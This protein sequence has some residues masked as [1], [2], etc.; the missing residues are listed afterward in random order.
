MTQYSAN[1]TPGVFWL[2]FS[3]IGRVAR[4][5][6]WLGFLIIWLVIGIA[7]NMWL[8]T[9]DPGMEFEA[10]PLGE[11]MSSNPLFPLLFFVLQWVQLALVIKR[12]QDRGITGF[13]A[14]LVF[15]PFLSM[16]V[17]IVLGIVPGTPG[18]NRYGPQSNSYYRRK[19]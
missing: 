8:K 18:P 14:L 4:E 17:V 10:L 9:L 13:L 19:A 12:C 1:T 15:L 6:Y 7:A 5:A 11:F 3:P 2:F 16:I